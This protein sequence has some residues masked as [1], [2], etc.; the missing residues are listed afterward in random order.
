MDSQSGQVIT[1]LAIYSL[2]LIANGK[3]QPCPQ[4]ALPFF[5]L[6]LGGHDF[7]HFSLVPNVSPTCSPQQLTFILQA[8]PNVVLLSLIQVGQRRGTLYFKIEPSILGSLHSFIFLCDGPIKLAHCKKKKKKLGRYL[9]CLV[10][11]CSFLLHF[12]H[13]SFHLHH[14]ARLFFAL[15]DWCFFLIVLLSNFLL[16]FLQGVINVFFLCGISPK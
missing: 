3:A 7:F 16:H 10:H 13:H 5:F 4:G 14:L 6:N 12:H 9:F 1:K 11:Q 8:L 2:I 15:F